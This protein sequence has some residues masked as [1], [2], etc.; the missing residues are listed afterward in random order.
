MTPIAWPEGELVTL[1]YT[2]SRCGKLFKHSDIAWA[3]GP[4]EGERVR[5]EELEIRFG[6]QP[7]VKIFACSGCI[8][9]LETAYW[10]WRNAT[11]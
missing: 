3:D 6:G 9:D 1:A 5:V 10:E 7:P 11:L 8:S 4:H 2:C